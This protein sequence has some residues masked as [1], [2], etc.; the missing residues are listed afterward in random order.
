MHHFPA[1]VVFL[2]DSAHRF[3]LDKKAKGAD[4]LN[5]VFQVGGPDT[6]PEPC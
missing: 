5:L 6:A 3:W 1:E 4:L 2:D